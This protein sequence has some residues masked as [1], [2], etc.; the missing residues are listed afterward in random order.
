MGNRVKIPQ[1]NIWIRL[2]NSLDSLIDCPNAHARFTDPLKDQI[3]PCKQL[4]GDMQ[5]RMA[6]W[7]H[8]QPEQ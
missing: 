8:L 4:R 1:I 6:V 7:C 3:S 2:S 5:R